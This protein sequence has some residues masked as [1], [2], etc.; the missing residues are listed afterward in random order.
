[1]TRFCCLRLF[2]V[3]Y[4]LVFFV[5]TGR[6]LYCTPLYKFGRGAEKL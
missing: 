2:V 6:W 3:V 4:K 5:L 1:M